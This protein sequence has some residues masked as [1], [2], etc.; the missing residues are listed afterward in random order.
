MTDNNT[1][2]TSQPKRIRWS[3]FPS[4]LFGDGLLPSVFTLTLVMFRR[5]GLNNAQAALYISILALPFILRPLFEM[6]VT[7]FRGTNKVWILSSEFIAALSLWAIAFT[8]PTGYWLHATMCFMPFVVVAG[9][10][11][12]IAASRF[13]IDDTADM[14]PNHHTLTTLFRYAAMLVGI[15]IVAMLAGNMEVVTRNTRYSWSFAFYIMAGV[16]FF[17]WLWHSIFL[18]GTPPQHIR[19]DVFGLHR[20]E[21]GSV[22]DSMTQGFRNRFMIYFLM[23]FILPETFMSVVMPLFLVDAPHNGGLGLSPQEFGLV[24]GTIGVSGLFAGRTLGCQLI[25]K[26]GLRAWM[27]PMA[28][29]TSAHGV[30]ALYLSSHLAAPLGVVSM[31]LLTASTALG[32]GLSAYSSAIERFATASHGTVLRRAIAM[33]IVALTS[34]LTGMCSGLIQINIGYRQF[35]MLAIVLYAATIMAASVYTFAKSTRF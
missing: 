15:G 12:H 2:K 21:Y 26:H 35:F 23:M 22:A 3:W 31:T 18:P 29:V 5:Y 9:M 25:R 33:A 17:L 24:Y 4:L 30:S 16:E 7:H 13:Y 1:N 32:L 11:R 14:S 8:L 10:F 19:K 28:I 34:V 6:T 20:R 27:M